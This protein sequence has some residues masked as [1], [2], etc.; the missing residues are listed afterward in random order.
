MKK[1]EKIKEK[2]YQ[3]KVDINQKIQLIIKNENLYI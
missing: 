3:N 1:E 2:V